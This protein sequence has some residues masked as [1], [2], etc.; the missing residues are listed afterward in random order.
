[1]TPTTSKTIDTRHWSSW[2][3]ATTWTTT[4]RERGMPVGQVDI[5]MRDRTGRETEYTYVGIP[6]WW[7]GAFHMSESLGRAYGQIF[8]GSGRGIGGRVVFE[9]E[10][11]E[12]DLVVA[13]EA[14]LDR[15]PARQPA[16]TVQR[17]VR[18]A[19]ARVAV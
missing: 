1:M 6:L 10:V 3:V 7:Y 13:L 15:R 17:R 11:A 9:P 5:R 8:R 12:V 14:S 4:G 19:A 16:K 2:I 18:P